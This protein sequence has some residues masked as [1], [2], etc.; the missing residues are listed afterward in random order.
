MTWDPVPQAGHPLALEDPQDQVPQV[1]LEDLTA[2]ED[3]VGLPQATQGLGARGLVDP[4]HHQGVEE[5][6]TSSTETET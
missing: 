2:W 5:A 1:H 4:R 3:Q 6:T